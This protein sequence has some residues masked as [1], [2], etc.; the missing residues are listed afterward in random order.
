VEFAVFSPSRL[1]TLGSTQPV[2]AGRAVAAL[3]PGDHASGKQMKKEKS[4]VMR[5][6]RQGE[7]RVDISELA[8]LLAKG[9][10]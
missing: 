4:T 5:N 2:V 10:R 7:E 8:R 3:A 9:L 6:A 1:Y